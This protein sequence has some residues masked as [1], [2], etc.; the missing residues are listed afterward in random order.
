MTLAGLVWSIIHEHNLLNGIELNVGMTGWS[1][2]GEH[3]TSLS[4][5]DEDEDEPSSP[6]F[7]CFEIEHIFLP[8][9]TACIYIHTF[10][11]CA[12]VIRTHVQQH[13]PPLRLK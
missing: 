9:Y 11:S 6:F 12:Y 3:L 8:C 1:L 10:A 2:K 7:I 13:H 5:L 4:L